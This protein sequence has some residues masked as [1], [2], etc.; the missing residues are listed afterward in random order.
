MKFSNIIFKVFV[1]AVSILGFTFCVT[2]DSKVLLTELVNP[3][4][5]KLDEENIYITDNATIHIYSKKDLKL[6]HQFG[7]I[8][9]GP[10]EFLGN[11]KTTR[12]PLD[13]YLTSKSIVVYSY[14]KV[15]YFDKKGVFIKELRTQD[16][17]TNFKPL[18]SGYAGRLM[19]ADKKMRYRTLNIYDSKL[20][21]LT[22]VSKVPHPLKDRKRGFRMAEAPMAFTTYKNRLYAAF[23]EDLVVK[24]YDVNGK[25]LYSIK[26][27]YERIKVKQADKD[28]LTN[29]IKTHPR[30]ESIRNYL[31]PLYFPEHFPALLDMFVSDGKIYAISGKNKKGKNECFTFN[32]DGTLLKRKI[33]KLAY[34][35]EFDL[36]PHY[37]KDDTLYQL[38]E[39]EENEKWHLLVSKL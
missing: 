2:A 24:V 12:A 33:I 16:R 14:N 36:S 26:H 4:S 9:E 19:I 29:F 25:Y 15:S 30:F 20:K 1:F 5:I 38:V 35:N 10:G 3:D 18:G 21:G 31:L 37:I 39:D 34:K 27:D 6:K 23:N 28:K 11:A 8:G 22:T 32:L 7:K 13:I 17:S